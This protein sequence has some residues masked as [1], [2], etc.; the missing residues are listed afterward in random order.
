MRLALNFATALLAVFYLVVSGVAT[1]QDGRADWLDIELGKSV[2][3][4]TPANATAIAITDPDVADV[5]TLGSGS[6]IQVQGISVG[7]TDLVIQLGQGTAP[8]IYEITVHRDLSDLIRRV[9][10]IVEGEAPSIFPLNG[11]IVVEGRVDDLNTLEQV[12]LMSSVYDEEFINLMS[13]GG[14]H[15][16]QLEVVFAEVSRSGTREL[17]INLLAGNSAISGGINNAASGLPVLGQGVSNT[18]LGDII[19]SGLVPSAGPD[20]FDIMGWIGAPYN[21]A[22]RIDVLS[23]NR[24]SK[25][26]AQPTLVALSGQKAEFLAGGELPV[27]TP[28][29]TGAVQIQFK[30]YGVK[31]VFVPTVLG[32]TT[33]DLRVYIEVSEPDFSVASRISGIDVPGFISRKTQSHVRIDSGMTFAMAGLLSESTVSSIDQIPGLGSIPV[34]ALFRVVR[35]T[36]EENELVIFVTPRLVRPLGPAEVPAPPGTTE[37]NNPNDIELFLLGLDTRPGS[38]TASPTG[39]VGLQR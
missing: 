11:R 38:R 26:L 36:R 21:V 30:D 6:K 9:D 27:A 25:V 12:A 17:G 13:V 39:D 16:V 15:Q 34:G 10:D 19:N 31:L 22:A 35:H 24:L 1:A 4:E 20:G 29:A 14:D 23:R 32:G 37:N 28:S 18:S 3:L 7:S 2:V 33:I 5:V 8:I